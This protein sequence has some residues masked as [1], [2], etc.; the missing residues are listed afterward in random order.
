MALKKMIGIMLIFCMIL[1]FGACGKSKDDESSS[2]SKKSSG[3]F[4]KGSDSNGD[5]SDK[6][7]KGLGALVGGNSDSES[8][9]SDEES[10]SD[11]SDGSTDEDSGT[12]SSDNSDNSSSDTSVNEEDPLKDMPEVA[13]PDG[14]PKDSFPIYMG[15]KVYLANKSSGDGVT[16]YQVATE[17]KG[18]IDTISKYY[19]EKL[20]GADNFS[21]QSGGGLTFISGKLDGMDFQVM[22]GADNNSAYT[23]I[24]MEVKVPQ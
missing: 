7:G 23:V 20:N 2:S 8:S 9:G 10:G 19:E 14:F 6:S 24:T 17:V 18:D 4:S 12:T 11:V 16:T 3:L 5:E 21:S 22:L 13:I 1:T 15:A